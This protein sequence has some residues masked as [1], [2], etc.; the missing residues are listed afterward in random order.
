MSDV[1]NLLL[2]IPA[3]RWMW[4]LS[5]VSNVGAAWAGKDWANL[6]I[7]WMFWGLPPLFLGVNQKEGSYVVKRV[8]KYLSGQKEGRA[9]REERRKRRQEWTSQGWQADAIYVAGKWATLFGIVAVVQAGWVSFGLW[10]VWSSVFGPF[11]LGL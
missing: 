2:F 4:L 1:M 3:I 7:W 9:G 10:V 6:V 11:S 5:I 8:G